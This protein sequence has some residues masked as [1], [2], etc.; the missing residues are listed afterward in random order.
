MLIGVGAIIL[1]L[2]FCLYWNVLRFERVRIIGAKMNYVE[3]YKDYYYK[4]E[5][6]S[7]KTI[8]TGS[9]IVEYIYFLRGQKDKMME[10]IKDDVTNE[11]E[12]L[13]EENGDIFY[14]YDISDDF[15]QVRIYE[16]SDDIDINRRR[17]LG[18]EVNNRISSLIALYHDIKG[19]R[20]AGL[21]QIVKFI[22]EKDNYK[23]WSFW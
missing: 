23:I 2:L 20:P 7:V 13:I 19:G 11:L 9:A 21:H 18:P 4:S 17:A 10:K 6:K 12:K 16:V 15:K 3:E 22:E 1:A 5:L 8:I 14:K